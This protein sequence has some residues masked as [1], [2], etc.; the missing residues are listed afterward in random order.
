MVGSI[1]NRIA[2]FEQL[3]A[4]SK[5]QSGVMPIAPDPTTGF[6]A[7]KA[8]EGPVMG[9]EVYGAAI[10]PSTPSS[11]PSSPPSLGFFNGG[12]NAATLKPEGRN[13]DGI[14]RNP[15]D[16][17]AED[18]NIG[19]SEPLN[20]QT[21]ANPENE[22]KPNELRT[23][24]ENDPKQSF[25]IGTEE[26][27]QESNR[28]PSPVDMLHNENE[29]VKGDTDVNENNNDN[30]QQQQQQLVDS[31]NPFEFFGGDS[32]VQNDSDIPIGNPTEEA[33]NFKEELNEQPKDKQN[34]SAFDDI[35]LGFD[36]NDNNN[37]PTPVNDVAR[38]D[39]P[40]GNNDGELSFLLGK[41]GQI[42]ND[43]QPE[44]MNDQVFMNATNE[45]QHNDQNLSV[46]NTS[47]AEADEIEN[48]FLKLIERQSPENTTDK[49]EHINNENEPNENVGSTDKNPEELFQNENKPSNDGEFRERSPP[50]REK[51][52]KE[53]LEEEEKKLNLDEGPVASITVSSKDKSSEKSNDGDEM[54]EVDH[55]ERS[56]SPLS[57]L[58]H[59]IDGRNHHEQYSPGI[60]TIDEDMEEAGA[61]ER[62]IMN[63]D[64]GDNGLFSH[65]DNVDNLY[66][67][68][69]KQ[70]QPVEE[71][72]V[73][74]LEP[75]QLSTAEENQHAVQ[76]S[77]G[78]K[79][80]EDDDESLADYFS[81]LKTGDVPANSASRTDDTDDLT[82]T[83]D[84]SNDDIED[85][86]NENNINKSGSDSLG[87]ILGNET[88]ANV[89][90]DPKL[91]PSTLDRTPSADIL[92]S[93][94]DDLWSEH[95]SLKSKGSTPPEANENLTG[96]LDSQPSPPFGTKPALEADEEV[97]KRE[98]MVATDLVDNTISLMPSEWLVENTAVD[99]GANKEEFFPTE[100][101]EP[102][103]NNNS[104]ENIMTSLFG[105]D[106][107]D[108]EIM[109]NMKEHLTNE[110][111]RPGSDNEALNEARRNKNNA[112]P[113]SMY[114]SVHSEEDSSRAMPTVPFNSDLEKDVEHRGINQ[115]KSLEKMF[116][117]EFSDT[118]PFGAIGDD[119]SYLK[120]TEEAQ[121]VNNSRGSAAPD[122]EMDKEDLEHVLYRG[123]DQQNSVN[124]LSS[125]QS[126][127]QQSESS[128][129]TFPTKNPPQS[130]ANHFP[131]NNVNHVSNF[132]SHETTGAGH[133]PAPFPMNKNATVPQENKQLPPRNEDNPPYT[134]LDFSPPR[135][136]QPHHSSGPPLTFKNPV[137]AQSDDS[138]SVGISVLTEDTYG[139]A[140]NMSYSVSEKTSISQGGQKPKKRQPTN[141]DPSK[142]S[143]IFRTASA[144]RDNPALH[145]AHSTVSE[146]TGLDSA[147]IASGGRRPSIHAKNNVQHLATISG[148]SF[149]QQK[150]RGRDRS[151]GVSPFGR[152]RDQSVDSTQRKPAPEQQHSAAVHSENP[153][154]VD[155]RKKE[156]KRRGF[157]WRSLSPFR[158]RSSK[159]NDNPNP[160]PDHIKKKEK[161]KRGR[162]KGRKKEN[163]PS[164]DRTFSQ[165]LEDEERAESSI[166]LVAV[167]D[168]LENIDR[169]TRRHSQRSASPFSRRDTP[170]RRQSTGRRN[171]QPDPFDGDC[172]VDEDRRTRT[173][174][175]Q[176][177]RTP[178][179]NNS[180]QNRRTPSRRRAASRQASE[181]SVLSI[182]T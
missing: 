75:K 42:E 76:A 24:P 71:M 122:Y 31:D 80:D 43:N 175:R 3:A 20:N 118:T 9:K 142:P 131:Q 30:Q 74:D 132:L 176:N 121:F 92:E 167:S 162:S 85:L 182:F 2:A 108:P 152:R 66:E 134:P 5:T 87:S 90:D 55:D 144:L 126:R 116:S 111:Q 94:F 98:N 153:Q 170:T 84:F 174:S 119:D 11:K 180:R 26:M 161:S 68:A 73:P 7:K 150:P 149:Q 14:N 155:N 171:V 177:R 36:G 35:F 40:I 115:S 138:I 86:K 104:P 163:T 133:P 19:N 106:E 97:I 32:D 58:G 136:H 70:P 28:I 166:P 6:S 79:G 12:N 147:S 65:F 17:A 46:E 48:D 56:I 4:T 143:P 154:H 101:Q 178:S 83:K 22:I 99:R 114:G 128:Q 37:T 95:E 113:Y 107:E 139:G 81:N 125:P 39:N 102:E 52:I 44:Q 146:L 62:P 63:P 57:F 64:S 78:Q 112:S 169:K 45:G 145:N 77:G 23:P 54:N 135:P 103:G 50:V 129:T 61:D 117:D 21:T 49:E 110:G 41:E 151:R 18:V 137:F 15:F 89:E 82:S 67:G 105:S 69:E 60:S 120:G 165:L 141:Q 38:D 59:K 25:Q 124:S 1:H 100:H 173:P 130:M 47:Y 16:L 157:S 51:S 168:E 33:I 160:P 156:K 164:I 109:H 123:E 172:S 13:N 159:K 179:R 91:K 96:P 27:D 53:I 148:S 93:N 158:R 34:Q 88:S 140:S 127:F 10:K 29:A 181:K 8:K 72:I